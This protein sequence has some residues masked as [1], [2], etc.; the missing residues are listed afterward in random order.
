MEDLVKNIKTKDSNQNS[1]D[2]KIS[3]SRSFSN[4][5][6]INLN[7]I[8][9]QSK[10]NKI[11]LGHFIFERKI[12]EGTFGKVILAKDEI[13]KEKVAIKILD[14]NKILKETNI[15]NL[16]REIKILK[17]LRHNNIVHLY[18]VIETNNF[19]YLIMEYIKGIELFDYINEKH[20]L[21]EEE[22]CKYY[23]QIIS[24][25]EYL[26]KMRIVH[27][28]LKP[29]N[30]IIADNDIIK[31]VD[32]GLSNTYLDENLLYTACGSPCYAAPEMIKGEKYSGICIDI[33]SSGV[34]LYAMLCGVLPFEDNDNDELYRKISKGKFEVPETLSD[35]AKD[36]L[37][38]ILNVDPNKRYNIEQ[39][40]NHP[41]FNQLNPK[42]YMS[43]G[44]LINKVIVPIDENIVDIMVNKYYLN[45][46]EIKTNLILNE[47]NEITTTYYLILKKIIKEGKNTIGD[48]RSDNFLNYIHN[49]KNQISN[50]NNN[51][52]LIINERVYGKKE[53]IETFKKKNIRQI[54]ETKNIKKH[55]LIDLDLFYNNKSE[56][57]IKDNSFITINQQKLNKHNNDNNSVT[58]DSLNASI[59]LT[60]KK[61]KKLIIK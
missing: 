56:K 44:L 28:D 30:L 15:S 45:K 52:D 50:Y 21:T 26:G 20:Y 46:E 31:I 23:Q 60:K 11:K 27:R 51:F 9:N 34:V 13:T 18:N 57:S 43:E 33:W 59:I 16:E 8:Y 37:H 61:K 47:H 41:W 6:H 10:K 36:I 54:S 29:E 7:T 55:Y 22:A 38:R 3:Y 19:L 39:I 42:L 24:G 53:F 25:I 48:M 17:L 58:K 35:N 12:G 5:K 49:K 32:F 40:K 1:T 2:G 14:K 4:L